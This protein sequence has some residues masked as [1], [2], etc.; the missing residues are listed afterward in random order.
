MHFIGREFAFRQYVEHL[1]TDIARGAD[2]RNLV[3]H[4]TASFSAAGF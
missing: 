1:P 4:G 3:S 2:D